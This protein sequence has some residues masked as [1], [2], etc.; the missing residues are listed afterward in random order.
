MWYS[1]FWL[2]GPFGPNRVDGQCWPS[3]GQVVKMLITVVTIFATLWLPWRG[4]MVYNTLAALYSRENIFMDLWYLMFAKTCI[5]INRWYLYKLETL[6]GSIM[7]VVN[8]NEWLISSAIN[9][10]LYNA[11]S[12]KFR[13][14]FRQTLSCGPLDSGAPTFSAHPTPSVSAVTASRPRWVFNCQQKKMWFKGSPQQ[15]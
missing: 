13:H 9:P 10:I 3:F 6:F 5:Y 8:S 12:T 4:L 7:S 1:W 2:E 14:A 11:L 15:P